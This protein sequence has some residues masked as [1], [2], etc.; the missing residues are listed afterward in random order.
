MIFEKMFQDKYDDKLVLELIEGTKVGALASNT[1][2]SLMISII[3]YGVV[4]TSYLV[5]FI[6]IH[7]IF[8]FLRLSVSKK[9]K[10]I[11]EKK[12]GSTIKCIRV[13]TLL[14]AL[15]G[16]SF[17]VI[18][19]LAMHYGVNDIELF[20]VSAIVVGLTAGS[21]GTMGSIYVIFA[22]FMVFSIL[23]LIFLMSY[24]GGR[25]FYL[26]V[27]TLII[28]LIAH[29]A[30]GFRLFLSHKEAIDLE[31]KFA[32]IYNKS[33][34]GIAIV[35]NKRILEC[36]DTFVKMFGY[37]KDKAKLLSASILD[38]M[39]K[40][41]PDGKSSFKNMIKNLKRAQ[42]TQVS[43]E[44]FNTKQNG[45]N[46]YVEVILSPME[47][48]DEM[49]THAIFRD[50][51]S[52]KKAELEIIRLNTTLEERVSKEV[53]KNREKDKQMLHQSKLAQMGE[54]ISMIAHQWRQPLA[55]I[56]AA[57]I[58]INIKAQLNKLEKETAIDASNKIA[59]YTKHLS[60]TIDDF[61]TFFKSNKDKQNTTYTELIES[62]LKIV[63]VSI[64]NKNIS[65]IK[66]LNS[67]IVFETYENELKQVLLNLIKNAE[68][69]LLENNIQDAKIIIE[70][71]DNII[72]VKDN[73]GGIP[74][75]IIDKIFEPYFS[76]K[77]EKNGTGLGLYMSKTIVEEHCNGKLSVTNDEDGAVFKI[78]L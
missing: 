45:N 47:L 23:P 30:S 3:L 68:D 51:D 20:F 32:T 8:L 25:M 31:K 49:V 65:I 18:A 66:N 50:I 7:A 28:Y 58:G 33:S 77:L 54:M 62:V 56:N 9:F 74:T 70:S 34:D 59:D 76:T 42:E 24:H 2:G 19:F 73:A 69:A 41:Q 26:L 15:S 52:R 55:A 43:F 67:T 37:D 1:F 17:S 10:R 38:V 22:N 4:P 72:L 53:E 21:I 5:Y 63:E 36:N 29:L 11:I 35:K 64:K 40:K 61:R 16:L 71:Y 57:A 13:Y 6:I 60:E 78:E 75:N 12:N 39:P 48:Q 44:W 27:I 46:F 14:V